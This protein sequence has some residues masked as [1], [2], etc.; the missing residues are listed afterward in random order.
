MA[1]MPIKC[2]ISVTGNAD[3]RNLEFLAAIAVAR[4]MFYVY[5]QSMRER[6]K[7]GPSATST[8]RERISNPC[9]IVHSIYIL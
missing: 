8:I 4:C 9:Y 6:D 5:K 1:A 7:R 3:M 2:A